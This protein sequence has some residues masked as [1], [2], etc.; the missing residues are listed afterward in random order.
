MGKL[1]FKRMNF[2]YRIFL[3]IIFLGFFDSVFA[4]SVWTNPITSTDPSLSDPFTSGDIV[5]VNLNVSGIGRGTGISAVTAVDRYNASGW[6]SATLDVNDYF[7]FTLTPNSTFL[8]NLNSFVFTSQTSGTGPIT[9]ALRSSLDGFASNIGSI[10]NSTGATIDL[11]SALYQNISSSVTF[12]LYAWNASGSSGTFSVNSFSFNGSVVST[13][14]ISTTSLASSSFAL[15]NCSSTSSSSLNFSSTGI[16]NTGNTYSVQLSNSAGSFSSP[17]TIGTLSSTSNSGTIDFTIPAGLLTGSGYF[18]RV[19][20]SNPAVTSASSSVSITQNG[21]CASN[22]TDYFRSRQS[23]NWGTA[24][25]WESSV[26]AVNWITATLNPTSTANTITIKNGHTVTIDASISADQLIIESGGIL[27]HTNTNTFTLNDGTGT[28]MDI[29][30]TYVIYGSVPAGSGTYVVEN[31]A[32]I[33]AD[34]NSGGT[35]DNIAWSSNTRVLFKT[36]SIFNWNTTLAFNTSGITFFPDNSEKPIFKISSTMGTIGGASNT[37]IN[38]LLEM[39]GSVTWGSAG[40]KTF[41]DGIIGSG[42][43]VQDNTSGSFI[44]NGTSA[45]LGGSGIITLGNSNGLQI[46]SPAIVSLISDKT[47]NGSAFPFNVNSGATLN[48]STFVVS[49]SSNFFLSADGKLGIGSPNGITS[50]SASGNIQTTGRSYSSSANYIYNGSE[51]QVTGNFTTTPVANTVYSLTVA[52]TG[53]S[54][55]NTVTLSIN[56]TTATLLY[57]NNG[58]FASGTNQTLKVANNGIVYGNGGNNPNS[59]SAG[60]IEFTGAGSTNGYAE[61][62]PSLYSVILNGGVDFNGSPNTHTA[63][64][65]NQLQLNSGAFVTAAPYYN[66]GS[67]LVYNTG[68]TYSRNAEWGNTVGLPGYPYNVTVQ[69]NTILDL[70]TNSISIAQLEMGGD[71]TIGNSTGWGKV[72]MNNSMNKPLSVGGNLII[73]SVDALSNSSELS[74]SSSIGG[75]LWLYGNFSRYNGSF[76]TDNDRAVFFKGAAN[77]SISTPNIAITPTDP[78][79]NFS[80]AVVDKS[81]GAEIITLNCPVGIIKLVTFNK[82][83]ITSSANNPLVV[84]DNANATGA[85][86]SSFVNGPVKKIG[87]DA[88]SFPVGKLVFTTPHYRLIGISGLSSD[89]SNAFTA[90]FMRAN[91]RLLGAVNSPGPPPLQW[92][93]QCEYWKLDRNTG[94]SSANVTL[95]WSSQSPCNQA[96]VNNPQYLVIAHFDAVSGTWNSHGNNG[97]YTGDNSA[98]TVTWNA[99]SSFSPFSLGTTDVRYNPLPQVLN[100]VSFSAVSRKADVLIEWSVMNNNDQDEYILE[101]SKDGVNFEVLKVVSSKVILNLASYSEADTKPWYGWNYYRIQVYDKQNRQK[102]SQSV[103]VWYGLGEQIRISPNPASEKIVINFSEPRSIYRIDIVNIS[104]QVLKQVNAIQFITEIN[105]SQLQAGMY[106]LRI[107]DKNGLITRPFVKK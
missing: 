29:Y 70:N 49:G 100:L 97:G 101:R 93:S 102:I 78:T 52:N 90:E 36:G 73:G 51:N 25:T 55:N 94:S 68:G 33:R 74:L 69:A 35:A 81:T 23:G 39:N 30:G 58:F 41:R 12:R 14:T 32:S 62:N 92:V 21:Y 26:D 40:T 87:D 88:F 4:Q 99:V 37:I 105:I 8:L 44:I 59:A 104:G 71:L 76:Y 9:F 56:N 54:G 86:T 77:A 24:N 96:Y 43:L 85:S 11:S 42:A 1:L 5:D 95:S 66:S 60:N 15:A 79:Q 82:G 107:L 2:Y 48:C 91:S 80:Y 10:T 20:S 83:I 103:K 22:S 64:I 63:A 61:Q 84:F 45:Q 53:S 47:I 19:V 75:D 34:G 6:N 18:V 46:I 65:M 16:F 57:L 67:S 7:S 28:D 106:Y 17:T 89:P 72:Y 50:G 13:N 3:C 31:G 27:I 38:G 98:G